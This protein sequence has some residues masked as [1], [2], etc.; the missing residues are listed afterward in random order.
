MK[1]YQTVDCSKSQPKEWYSTINTL[2]MHPPHYNKYSNTNAIAF[3]SC[4]CHKPGFS[5]KGVMWFDQHY[6]CNFPCIELE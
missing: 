6:C 5:A 4:E 2:K 3:C 1:I